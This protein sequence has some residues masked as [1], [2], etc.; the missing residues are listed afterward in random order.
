VAVCLNGNTIIVAP[1]AV[2]GLLR[3]GATLGACSILDGEPS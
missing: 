2:E 3:A 1:R